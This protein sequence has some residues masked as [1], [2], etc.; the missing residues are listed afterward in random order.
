[1]LRYIYGLGIGIGIG[2][3]NTF[4]FSIGIANT[5]NFQYFGTFRRL[6][7]KISTTRLLASQKLEG[8]ELGPAVSA[9][10]FCACGLEFFF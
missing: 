9:C 8:R 3:A 2:I 1:M 10:R 6:W 4:D 7:V 5:Q